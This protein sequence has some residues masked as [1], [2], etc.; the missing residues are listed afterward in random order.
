MRHQLRRAKVA[1]LRLR[2]IALAYLSDFEAAYT[3]PPNRYCKR[4]ILRAYL[5]AK[6]VKHGG[7][8]WAGT[9]FRIFGTGCV[10]LG[11]RCAI[12]NFS[13]VTAHG[14]V[15]IGE[16]FLCSSHL[17]INSGT[18]DIRTRVP[19]NTRILIGKNVWVGARVTII[20]D[21]EIS[22]NSIVAAGAV[23]RGVFP[24]GSLLA[25][26]PAKVVR[27][28]EAPPSESWYFFTRNNQ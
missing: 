3:Y 22:D 15:T 23:V 20:G 25:G 1:A 28:L 27:H 24:A 16:D 10:E 18:H 9:Q 7:P 14:S 12:G 21:T 13:S 4:P 6:R 2:E 11:R 26:V 8:V 17:V 5:Q 19:Q